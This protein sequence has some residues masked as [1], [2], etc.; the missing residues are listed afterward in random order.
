MR[1]MNNFIDDNLFILLPKT[2]TNQ[3]TQKVLGSNLT[4]KPETTLK[5]KY[6]H[7]FSGLQLEKQKSGGTIC[8]P[9]RLENT[10][11]TFH[12]LDSVTF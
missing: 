2:K 6:K 5:E 1:A 10:S 7:Q 8:F 9:D 4:P 11:F 12:N 3:Y